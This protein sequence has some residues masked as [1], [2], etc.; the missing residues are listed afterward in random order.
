M[1]RMASIQA[2]LR[3]NGLDVAGL[4]EQITAIEAGT[5]AKQVD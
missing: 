2:G 1:Q 3:V 5:L 4:R